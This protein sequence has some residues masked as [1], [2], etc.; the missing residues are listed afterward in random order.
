MRILDLESPRHNMGGK[1]DLVLKSES[2]KSI[3]FSVCCSIPL[4]SEALNEIKKCVY[5]S[6]P[7][8]FN[9][10]KLNSI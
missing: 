4:L 10:L 7:Y 6:V 2:L 3:D 8:V 1:K 9:K 5:V